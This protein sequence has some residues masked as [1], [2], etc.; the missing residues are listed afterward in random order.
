MV[1]CKFKYA[2]VLKNTKQMK[3]LFGNITNSTKQEK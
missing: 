1:S 2:N 3:F